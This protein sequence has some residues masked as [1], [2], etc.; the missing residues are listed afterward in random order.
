MKAV[1]KAIMQFVATDNIK[2]T[3]GGDTSGSEILA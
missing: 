2:E 1:I 3:V